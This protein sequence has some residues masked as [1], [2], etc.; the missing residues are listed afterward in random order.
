MYSVLQLDCNHSNHSV[1]KTCFCSDSYVYILLTCSVTYLPGNMLLLVQFAT[2]KVLFTNSWFSSLW[3]VLAVI[4][5]A[6]RLVGLTKDTVWLK[7]YWTLQL[8]LLHVI[9]LSA[10]RKHGRNKDCLDG[11]VEFVCVK[12][13]SVLCFK[14]H[15]HDVISSS[16]LWAMRIV[17][18]L[19]SKLHL[20]QVR[21]YSLST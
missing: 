1:V 6:W 4:N 3:V 14:I 18:L 8:Y 7:L 17:L 5:G 12:R 19:L 9:L 11:L 15:F 16:S 20:L 13:D 2:P 10:S 21:Y